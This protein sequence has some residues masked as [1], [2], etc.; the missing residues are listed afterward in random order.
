MKI[1]RG[2]IKR[3]Q[4][5]PVGSTSTNEKIRENKEKKVMK[6]IMQDNFPEP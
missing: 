6:Q 2:K 4:M 3:N 5:S 1:R